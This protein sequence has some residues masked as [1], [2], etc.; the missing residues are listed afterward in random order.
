MNETTTTTATA[1]PAAGAAAP[2]T[3][4]KV[5]ESLTGKVVTLV[6]PESYEDAPVGRR[7]VAGFY[8]GKVLAVE[9]VP[10][11][12]YKILVNSRGGGQVTIREGRRVTLKCYTAAARCK[13]Q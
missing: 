5:L 4:Q 8:R 12:T 1:P 2:S 10:P 3:F 6:N 11:G 13:V 9:A 7:L